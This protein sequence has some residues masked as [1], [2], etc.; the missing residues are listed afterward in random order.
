MAQAGYFPADELAERQ[1][2][3]G[4]VP[5]P[6]QHRQYQ[7]PYHHQQDTYDAT[8]SQYAPRGHPDPSFSRLRSQRRYNQEPPNGGLGAGP[9][10]AATANGHGDSASP[11][12]SF[13]QRPTDRRSWGQG[14]SYPPQSQ[15]PSPQSTVTPGAD[16]FSN[17]AAGGMAGIALTIAEQNARESGLNAIHNQQPYQQGQV[18]ADKGML[19]PDYHA[20]NRNSHSSLQGLSAAAVGSG[21]ATPGQRTPSRIGGEVYTDDPYQ[22]LSRHVD[23]NLGVVNPLDIADDGD[24]GLEYGRKGPR[25]SMLSLGSNRSHGAAAA[26]GAAA[27]GVLGGLVGRNGSGS[28]NNQY[29]P[30]HTG[31]S[32]DGASGG[33]GLG[34]G[35]AVFNAVPAGAAGEKAWEAAALSKGRSSGK[36]WKIAIIAI[37]VIVILAAIVLGVLFG[38]VFRSNGGGSSSANSGSGDTSTAA[39]DRSAHGDLNSDSSEIQA[40]M[41]NPDLRKVFPGMDY[42]PLNT[43]YPDCM[44]NPPS[45]NN[46]T[47]DLAV[48]SQLTNVVRL[49]GTDCNQTQMLIHAVDQLK[50]KDKVKIWLGVWQD[51]NATTNA[52]QLSQMWDILDQ[53]DESYFKGIIVANEI[54]FRQQMTITTLGSLLEEVRANL[55]ARGLKLPVATSDLG[56]KWDAT[57]A[58]QSDAIMANIHPFFAGAKASEA[59]DWT[60][61]FWG[62]KTSSFLK[63]D[64]A[65]NVIAETGWPSQGGMACGT[66]LETNCPDRA[67]AGIDELN[68]FMEDW[69]CRALDDGTEYFWFEAFDEPWKIMFNTDGKEWEDHWGLMTVDRKLKDGVKIPDCGGKR[70]S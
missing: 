33:S 38:A 16:N 52:R 32:S 13:P 17:A 29:A 66:E 19:S 68:T 49:Y 15:R 12:R 22:N 24:D 61:Y 42:T 5:D 23:S 43:Q 53:Y 18:Y 44:H 41:N 11:L 27:G 47:R 30:V 63:R 59:A 4:S 51:A 64:N 69:V 28:V 36:K 3:D 25:T 57:L 56:D 21:Y 2:L 67:V 37:V 60:K 7:Q 35:G 14:T 46:I 8:P 62:N 10:A 39:G 40:L 70:V 54:L 45:Q 50:L 6:L 31:L 58:S 26:G 20:G 65:M 1:P 55:T 9:Y 34:S 48:L